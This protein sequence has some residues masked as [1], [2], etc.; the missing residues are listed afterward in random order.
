MAMRVIAKRTLRRFWEEHRDAEKPLRDWYAIASATDWSSSIAIKRQYRSASFVGDGRV[1]FNIAGNKYRL[2]ALV[3]YDKR[4]MFVRF[5]GSHSDYDKI[6][7]R[8]V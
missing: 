1:V 3:R 7:A 2:V 4:L 5:V 6:D 8:T